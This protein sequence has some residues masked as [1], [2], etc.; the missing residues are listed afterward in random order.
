MVLAIFGSAAAGGGGLLDNS[1]VLLVGIILSI[2]IFVKF[3]T[4][5]KKFELSG[6]AKKWVFILTGLGLVVFNLLYAK[7]NSLIASAGDL[8][9]A[10]AALV[11]SIVWV[12]IFAFALMAETKPE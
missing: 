2:F 12:F 5:S 4:W 1:L 9:G 3:C 8:S 6:G 11:A 7:G 10:T